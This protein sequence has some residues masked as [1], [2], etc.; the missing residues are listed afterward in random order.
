VAII[1]P[2]LVYIYPPQGQTST[3]DVTI[4]LDKAITDLNNNDAV[5]FTAPSETGFVMKDGG[6]DN[7]PGAVAFAGWVAKDASGAVSVFATNCSHL[8]CSVAW[9]PA[10]NLF[11]CPCHGSRFNIDGQVAHGPAVYPLSHLTWR[12]GASAAEIIV[13]AYTLKGIG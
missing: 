4:P 10:D 9:T 1:A 3:K 7:S 8:G 13:Q 12:Q 11:E 2:I 6:G 5:R